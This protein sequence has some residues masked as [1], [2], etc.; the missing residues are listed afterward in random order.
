[1]AALSKLESLPPELL[2]VIA[3]NLDLTG[4]LSFRVT[5]RTCESVSQNAFAKKM[6]GQLKALNLYQT[7]D[8]LRLLLSLSKIPQCL[9]LIIEIT[10][11]S[12]HQIL[13]PGPEAPDIMQFLLEFEASSACL[14]LWK[15]IC[16]VFKPCP[17]FDWFRIGMEIENIY[18]H[19]L[20]GR[21]LVE[22]ERQQECEFGVRDGLAW[23]HLPTGFGSFMNAVN[24]TGLSIDSVYMD[25]FS[26]PSPIDRKFYEFNLPEAT[27]WEAVAQVSWDRASFSDLDYTAVVNGQKQDQIID[28]CFQLATNASVIL[29][30]GDENRSRHGT[31]VGPTKDCCPECVQLLRP[32]HVHTFANLEE[33]DC[34][35]SVHPS[36]AW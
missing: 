21:Q 9:K 11:I 28:K 22:S 19:P 1:M 14:G 24:D 26:R 12:M 10:I 5:S 31:K 15:E 32:L 17:T 36:L 25:M 2:D 34:T 20:G 6:A 29:V 3:T 23:W 35:I 4:L 7:E 27:G 18:D 16:E 8:G 13:W 33:L 30:H